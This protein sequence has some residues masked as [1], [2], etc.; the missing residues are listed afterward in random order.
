MLGG[1]RNGEC[2]GHFDGVWI[3]KV[4]VGRE[5]G[6]DRQKKKRDEKETERYKNVL[7]EK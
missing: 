3:V 7:D 2:R 6:E 1:I 4:E 5:G